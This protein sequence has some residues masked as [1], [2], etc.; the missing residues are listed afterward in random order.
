MTA[1]E[2]EVFDPSTVSYTRRDAAISAADDWR[3]TAIGESIAGAVEEVRAVETK[4][5]SRIVVLIEVERSRRFRSLWLSPRAA[6][7]LVR[8]RPSAGDLIRVTYRG[9]YRSGPQQG[10]RRFAFSLERKG[11]TP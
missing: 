11:G 3:P 8:Q 6:R 4:F 1:E 9:Q 10:G 5:G 2:D 7:S